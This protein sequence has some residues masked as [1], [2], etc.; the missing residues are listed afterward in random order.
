LEEKIRELK[1][2]YKKLFG[3]EIASQCH[4]EVS[5][6]DEVVISA[7]TFSRDTSYYV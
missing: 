2:C 3:D 4:I 7:N 5:D 6:S 1:S